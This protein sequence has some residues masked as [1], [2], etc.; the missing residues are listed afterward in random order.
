MTAGPSESLRLFAGQYLDRLEELLSRLDLGALGRIIELLEQTRQSGGTV[1]LIG[2]GGSAST[3]SHMALDLA[4]GTRR[5]AGPRLRTIALTESLPSITA[6]ANDDSYE[7][8]FV[9]QLEPLLREGDVLIAISASGNSPNVVRAIEYA[10]ASGV[11]TI[12]LVGFDGGRLKE[13]C[14][15]VLHIESDR[16]E[17]GPVEDAH[18]IL[19]HLITSYLAAQG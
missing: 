17:Y 8:V 2:N 12:G 3:A 16:G 5:R 15:I 13:L 9:E 14:H 19:N 1:Y 10:E 11:K 18:L 7:A 4:Y 6:T